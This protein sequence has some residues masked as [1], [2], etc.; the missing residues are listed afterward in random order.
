MSCHEEEL[1]RERLIEEFEEGSEEIDEKIHQILIE[2][3]IAWPMICAAL[4][5]NLV[6]GCKQMFED[7][8]SFMRLMK[9]SWNGIIETGE[10]H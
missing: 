4:A 9:S 10:V 7:E 8:E 3:E 2:S 5:K 1:R 6:I